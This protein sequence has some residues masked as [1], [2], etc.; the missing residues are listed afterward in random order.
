MFFFPSGQYKTSVRG[1]RVSCFF[2][3]LWLMLSETDSLTLLLITL[4][5]LSQLSLLARG[6]AFPAIST[7]CNSVLGPYEIM[8]LHSICYNALLSLTLP[9]QLML[10]NWDVIVNYW[11]VFSCVMVLIRYCTCVWPFHML[12]KK[13]DKSKVIEKLSLSLLIICK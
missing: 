2:E 8:Y 12:S 7:L 10:L 1:V 4:W 13:I 6:L 11:F 9:T 5:G 3:I